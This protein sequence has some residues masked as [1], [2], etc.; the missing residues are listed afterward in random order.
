MFK[1]IIII[2]NKYTI[3]FTINKLL[4][5]FNI[6]FSPVLFRLSTL[7]FVIRSFTLSFLRM[8]ESSRSTWTKSSSFFPAFFEPATYVRP[9]PSQPRGQSV[10]IQNTQ[11]EQSGLQR[12]LICLYLPPGNV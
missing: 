11:Q 5:S 12:Y 6:Y 10:Y 3:N 4:L 1:L 8:V 7:M 9:T 2:G